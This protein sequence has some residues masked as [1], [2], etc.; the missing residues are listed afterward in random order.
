[1]MHARLASCGYDG[2]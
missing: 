1:M 2:S